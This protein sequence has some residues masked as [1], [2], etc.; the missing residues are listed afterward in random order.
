MNLEKQLTRV[1]LAQ[2]LILQLSASDD[3]VPDQLVDYA[4]SIA[5]AFV[6]RIERDMTDA[7]TEQALKK[8]E[9]FA[10]R[11]KAGGIEIK[12]IDPEVARM[13]EVIARHLS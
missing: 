3:W 12:E 9:E 1:K 2:E 11:R 13:L 7:S 5:D 6:E 4:F 10:E 8:A